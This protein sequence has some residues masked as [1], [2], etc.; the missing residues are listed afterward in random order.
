[1]TYTALSDDQKA[2]AAS[3]CKMMM[4][5]NTQTQMLLCMADE[6]A[7]VNLLAAFL[8]EHPEAQTKPC[9]IVGHTFGSR[10]AVDC[11]VGRNIERVKTQAK[12]GI[13]L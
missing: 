8:A 11:L 4:G 12:H 2:R 1:M 5:S 9:E 10:A 6:A 7:S 13:T 3:Q